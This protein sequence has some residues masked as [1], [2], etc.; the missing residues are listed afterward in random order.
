VH[1]AN[2]NEDDCSSLFIFRRNRLASLLRGKQQQY[3]ILHGKDIHIKSCVVWRSS[4]SLVAHA[5]S[6]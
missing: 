4:C 2:A 3:Y 5:E 6:L 1:P